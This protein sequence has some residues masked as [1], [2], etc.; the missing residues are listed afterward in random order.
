MKPS[1]TVSHPSHPHFSYSEDSPY[2]RGLAEGRP[3]GHGR[4]V[5]Y[6]R[7]GAERRLHPALLSRQEHAEAVSRLDVHLVRSSAC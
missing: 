7:D 3:E 2:D 5:R 6:R 4:V 1:I